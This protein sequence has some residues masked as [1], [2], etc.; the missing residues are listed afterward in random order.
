MKRATPPFPIL[1]VD[2]D[3]NVLQ[4]FELSL[5]S[6]GLNNVVLCRDP[7]EASEIIK[8]QIFELVMLDLT[9]PGKSGEELLTEIAGEQPDLPIVVITG[10]ND[11]DTAVKCM[12]NG[13]VDYLLKPVEKS[14][15]K[16]SVLRH[17]EFHRLQR[18]NQ[19]MK[20]QLLNDEPIIESYFSE[21]ITQNRGMRAIFKYI[22]VVAD[23]REP[24]LITGETGVGKELL[25]RAIHKCSGLRGDFVPVNVAGLD[26]QVFSDTLF[27]HKKG[28]FTDA[29]QSRSG[30]VE[31]AAGGTL[32]LDE[33][34]DLS[35]SSQIKLL[36]LLQEN[37]YYSLGSDVPQKS[38]IRVVAST[39]AAIEKL[40][41][42]ENFRKDLFF[43]LY[44]HHIHIPPLRER[45][46]DIPLLVGHFMEEATRRQDKKAM[47]FPVELL[48]LLMQYDF[49]GNIRELRSL[50]VDAVSV[51]QS[52][53]LSLKKFRDRFLPRVEIGEKP[54]KIPVASAL[55]TFFK[56]PL[57]S[58]A[59]AEAMLI[60]KA[61]EQSG[62]NQTEASRLLGI[63]RQ[64][65]NKKLKNLK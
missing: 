16:G 27:G 11:I 57:P 26:D 24:I 39:N 60:R 8:S 45:L 6:F 22:R 2:D 43:R 59:E 28:A 31:K 17:L 56:S 37:E 52:G 35:H 58:L 38:E 25:A 63:A 54:N 36:R 46:D 55:D 14:R 1:V 7:L 13:A 32:F 33:I 61:M 15:L 49:P 47:K 20:R 21:I 64:T 4:S 40:R 65:L 3:E 44:I 50:I 5:R 23:S 53:S 42:S 51:R 19:E 12:Q 29:F 30:L 62:G 9:M 18:E 41:D 10:K 48:S 34:G